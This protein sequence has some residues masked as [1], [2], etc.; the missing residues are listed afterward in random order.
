MIDISIS[1]FDQTSEEKIHSDSINT[2]Q[3]GSPLV[4]KQEDG[5]GKVSLG[6]G[7][8]DEKFAGFAFAGY[9]RPSQLLITETFNPTA[10]SL[11]YVA[12]RKPLGGTITVY[13]VTDNVA[14][15]VVTTAPAA[16]GEVQFTA[17]SNTIAFYA[18]D[19]GKTFNVTYRYDATVTEA[20]LAT[21]D[22]YPSGFLLGQLSGT[23]GVC[24]TGIISTDQVDLS[25]DWT[26]ADINDIKVNANGL[27]TRGGTGA[28]ITNGRVV[29]AP[30]AQS[31]NL[32]IKLI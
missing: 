31:S 10:T 20:R 24:Y 14:A 15:K 2:I 21:G 13:N 32:V 27:V 7:S 29:A 18:S 23:T 17:A 22:G 9:V 6:T 28:A 11:S 25:V 3:E 1:R 4:W 16:A 19:A 30:G 26:E 5:V 12:A 8:D